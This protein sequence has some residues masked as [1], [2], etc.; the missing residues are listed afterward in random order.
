MPESVSLIPN[1]T[2]V[3]YLVDPLRVNYQSG[4]LAHGGNV[5]RSSSRALP[6]RNRLIFEEEFDGIRPFC[7]S[8]CDPLDGRYSG[9]A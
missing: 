3:L 4:V 2:P 5:V 9:I 8:V 6:V 7:I 1:A